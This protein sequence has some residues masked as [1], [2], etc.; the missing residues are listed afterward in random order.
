[1]KIKQEKLRAYLDRLQKDNRCTLCGAQKWNVSDEVFTMIGWENH[2]NSIV[3]V[4]ENCGKMHFVHAKIAGLYD[5]QEQE[6]GNEI[7]A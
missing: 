1:M 2:I 6:G 7:S 4:C 5:E 3:I